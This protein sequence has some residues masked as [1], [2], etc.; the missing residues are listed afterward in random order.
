M[1]IIAFVINFKAKVNLNFQVLF[2]L[3]LIL[4]QFSQVPIL[5]T[6][7][8]ITTTIQGFP[9]HIPTE[10]KANIRSFKID[11][12]SLSQSVSFS[13]IGVVSSPL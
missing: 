12:P 5:L 4:I 13:Q 8:I 9:S 11:G 1:V 2:I 3:I 6:T 10:F 7:I